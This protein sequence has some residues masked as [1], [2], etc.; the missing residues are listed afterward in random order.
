MSSNGT[1][2]SSSFCSGGP[3][4]NDSMDELDQAQVPDA[5]LGDEDAVVPKVCRI[6]VPF[7]DITV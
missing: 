4:M 1:I 6:N 3:D 7:S 5:F 2:Y